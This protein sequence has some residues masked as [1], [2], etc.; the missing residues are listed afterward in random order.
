[1]G[2]WLP[3][4]PFYKRFLVLFDHQL[5][6]S[7]AHR[8]QMLNLE[9]TAAADDPTAIVDEYLNPWWDNPNNVDFSVRDGLDL[10]AGKVSA[11]SIV[12]P[13]LANPP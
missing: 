6:G 12:I 5:Q 3:I 9:V 4:A 11:W 1:M 7:Q 10:F 8:A 2:T 13:C